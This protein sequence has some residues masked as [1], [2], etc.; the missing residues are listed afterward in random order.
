[1]RNHFFQFKQF[2]IVQEKSALKVCTDSCLFGAVV[3]D[4]IEKNKDAFHRILDI[5]GGTGL[6]SLMLAQKSYATIDAVEIDKPSFAEME[7]NF[8]ASPWSERLTA[9]CTDIKNYQS[10][11]KY[12][13]II[14]NPPFFENQL[15]S[16][17]GH[18]NTAKHQDGLTLQDLMACIPSLLTDDGYLAILLPFERMDYFK[19]IANIFGYKTAAS[20]CVQQTPVHSFFRAILFLNKTASEPTEQTLIIKEKTGAY[21]PAFMNLLHDYYL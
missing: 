12:D 13:L 5:G 15:K 18:K 2:K 8:A 9:F 1:M 14:S 4:K 17:Q 7:F 20:Y 16:N 19:S 21:T 11:K 3:A 6:L 10:N